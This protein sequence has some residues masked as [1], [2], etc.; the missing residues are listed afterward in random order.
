MK[1]FKTALVLV[2]ALG[3]TWW[4]IQKPGNDETTALNEAQESPQVNES[5]AKGA[6]D[7]QEKSSPQ[8]KSSEKEASSSTSSQEE[9]ESLT[10]K[11]FEDYTDITTKE[12][13][14]LIQKS[15][16]FKR[17]AHQNTQHEGLVEEL[18]VQDARPLIMKD[19]NPY[20]GSMNVVRTRA[21]IPGTRYFHAQ[22]FNREDG[23]EYLQHMSFEFKASENS[24]KAVE[25][26]MEKTFGL[27]GQKIESKD[28]FT[29]WRHGKDYVVWVK[30]L[31]SSDLKK[32][33][34]FNAYSQDDVGTIRAAIEL[35]IHGSAKSFHMQQSDE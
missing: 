9:D 17:Y 25:K 11:D 6:K 20:T 30:K 34:P 14:S 33:D 32:N 13:E 27:Q 15:E 7:G 26:T 28:G 1:N 21:P 5:Q 24:F 31:A 18:K 22:F 35:E 2:V 12:K 23:G 10:L 3:A 19:E 4:L 29:S 16:L 8:N